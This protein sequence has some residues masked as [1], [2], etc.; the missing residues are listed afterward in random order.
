MNIFKIIS[1]LLIIIF[2]Y[3]CKPTDNNKNA[4]KPQTHQFA[5]AA[6]TIYKTKSDYS[7]LVPIT[8]N[9]QKNKIIAYPAVS[10][11]RRAQQPI[12]LDSGFLLDKRGIGPNSVFLDYTYETYSSLQETPS[13]DTLMAHIKITDP[14]DVIYRCDRKKVPNNDPENFINNLIRENELES[15]CEKI[16]P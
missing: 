15:I 1:Y 2:M 10:D 13:S 16:Y 4:S 14:F 11:I 8:L 6:I 3:S 7:K 5:Q 9:A 12:I